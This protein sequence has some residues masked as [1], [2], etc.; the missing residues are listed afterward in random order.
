MSTSHTTIERS[1][2]DL[3]T[4]IAGL[5]C[6]VLIL[7]AGCA[8]TKLKVVATPEQS[9]V[10]ITDNGGATVASGVAPVEAPI[11]FSK[12]DSYIVTVEPPAGTAKA[13]LTAEEQ[14]TKA[15]YQDL[16]RAANDNYT[17]ELTLKLSEKGV[18]IVTEVVVVLTPKGE[19]RGVPT[20]S[21]AYKDVS[22]T[23][24]AIPSRVVEFSKNIAVQGLALSPDGDHIA[25]S[26]ANYR[27][28]IEDLQKL[29]SAA[30]PRLIDIIGAN[31]H[32][33]GVNQGGIQ[34]I[35][36]ENFRDMFPSFTADGKFLLFSSNRRR[37]NS[38]DLLMMNWQERTGIVNVYLDNRDGRALRP[39]QSK[40]GIIGFCLE[41]AD[42]QDPNQRFTIWTLG[43]PNKYPTL[44]GTGSQP[45]ISPDGKRMAYIGADG[46]LWVINVDGAQ[47]TQLT[48]GAEQ[49]IK[50]YKESL[51]PEEQ[52]WYERVV[53]ELGVAEKQPYSYPSWSAD[54]SQIVYTAMEGSD[55][56]G[57]PNEDIWVMGF[58]GSNKRQM[59]TNGSIDRYPLLSPDG[60][61][62][63]FMSNRGGQWAIWRIQAPEGK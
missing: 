52:K 25:Y 42:P 53:D 30:E 23:G 50:R 47:A 48:F 32:I 21:R 11:N 24:G 2:A 33:A 12:S 20:K 9:T 37:A 10:R 14:I 63:Y 13:Y 35:T 8:T 41:V 62:I 22:E 28:S 55:P 3:G 34:H 39:T 59:T 45:S 27:Q 56:S 15:R 49:I 61:H 36:S 54:G 57:R 18:V 6:G 43:G 16:P 44:I 46:N 40:E 60:K 38:E 29:A 26:A 4:L 1:R 58:D 51:S 7:Q 19:W 17:R 31:L 5:L